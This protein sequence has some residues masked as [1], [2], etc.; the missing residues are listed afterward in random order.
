MNEWIKYPLTLR[1]ENVELVSLERSHFDDLKDLAKE[2][3]IWEFYIVA[4]S[5]PDK[6]NELYD[7]ALKE[8]DT[9]NQYPFVIIHKKENKII[10]ST[11]F[12]DVQ[13][14]NRKLEI[15][16]TWLHPDYWS[17]NVNTECK[18]LMLTFCFEGLNTCRVQFRTD[19]KNLRSRKA[20]EKTGAKYEGTIRNDMIRD[21]GT[22]R[23]SALFS[24][25]D[26]EWA[27]AKSKLQQL[28]HSV[29]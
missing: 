25:T 27:D 19:E 7:E 10:G 14:E 22:K 21:N 15:G 28:C 1:G 9:G 17:T 18:L 11:R 8:R 6:F 23:N 20:I 16:W 3:R 4:F 24:I 26:D 29:K 2:K 5:D 13:K 12:L